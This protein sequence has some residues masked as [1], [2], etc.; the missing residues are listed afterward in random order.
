MHVSIYNFDIGF[1]RY[2]LI[3]CLRS[4]THTMKPLYPYNVRKLSKHN[5]AVW[6]TLN[7][8]G[9]V[10][11]L[12]TCY[13]LLYSYCNDS[14]SVIPILIIIADQWIIV[15]RSSRLRGHGKPG[16]ATSQISRSGE[17]C[18]IELSITDVTYYWHSH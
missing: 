14:K 5:A 3:L 2:I 7:M 4:L 13:S 16:V 8:I 12:N 9:P 11:I 6:T 10:F 15:P 1:V 18:N 17:E